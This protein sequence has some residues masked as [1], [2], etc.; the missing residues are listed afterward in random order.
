M[1]NWDEPLTPQ[2]SRPPE[3][4]MDAPVASVD[5]AVITV[6]REA[7]RFDE[8]SQPAPVPATG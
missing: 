8:V 2:I 7:K 3:P 6:A 5:P 4:A 1:L